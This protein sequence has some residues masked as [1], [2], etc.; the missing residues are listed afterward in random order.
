MSPTV[1]FGMG[2]CGSINL[3]WLSNID[4]DH[5]KFSMAQQKVL[6]E[7]VFVF[8]EVMDLMN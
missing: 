6:G 2:Y 8:S 5:R 4:A 3:K 1:I 7:T